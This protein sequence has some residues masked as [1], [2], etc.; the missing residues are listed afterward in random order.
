MKEIWHGDH[1]WIRLIYVYETE[2][3]LVIKYYIKKDLYVSVLNKSNGKTIN[4]KYDQVNDDCGIG[5]K[6]PLPI[7]VYK[8][9]FIGEIK[10]FDIDRDQ[11]TN[12]QLKELMGDVSEESNQIL[13]FYTIKI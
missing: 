8:N 2:K 9:R 11:V 6:F 13:V 1:D 4:F 5:G 12:P 10:P 3:D 7:G